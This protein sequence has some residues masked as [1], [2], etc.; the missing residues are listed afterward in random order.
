M[1][2][3][4]DDVAEDMVNTCCDVMKQ[5]KAESA[6]MGCTLI[7]GYYERRL[8]RTGEKRDLRILNC[9]TLAL[10]AAELL[11]DLRKQGIYQINRSGFL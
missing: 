6:I 4:P 5:S 7:A 1:R 9:N 11:A 8:R 10:K 3:D 2:S